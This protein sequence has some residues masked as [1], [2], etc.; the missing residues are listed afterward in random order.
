MKIHTHV[1]RC[2]ARA[3][4]F[5]V[6]RLDFLLFDDGFDRFFEYFPD[7]F[8][9]CRRQ[10]RIDLKCDV[11][12]NDHRLKRTN[13]APQNIQHDRLDF[14]RFQPVPLIAGIKSFIALNRLIQIQTSLKGNT[15][16]IKRLHPFGRKLFIFHARSS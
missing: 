1:A 14:L 13:D 11:I 6:F 4:A 12:R 15:L 9:F 5:S 3:N 2:R 16:V 10:K 8:P 7:R